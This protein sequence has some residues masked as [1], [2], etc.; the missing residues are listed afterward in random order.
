[1]KVDKELYQVH[2]NVATSWG[3]NTREDYDK[4]AAKFKG[5][6][7][8]SIA[9][10]VEDESSY[11]TIVNETFVLDKDQVMQLVLAG[12]NFKVKQEIKVA[13]DITKEIIELAEKPI[14][15]M[16]GDGT[17]GNTYNNRCEV[18]MPGNAMAFY[19]EVLLKE[20]ACTD[21]LQTALHSGWRLIA[22]CPQPNQ[23]RPDY[24]LGRFNPDLEIDGAA[25]R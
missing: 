4:E 18:H 16:T 12:I 1:M 17:I 20:D 14:K 22:A 13:L 23:R 6:E 8:L 2:V 19:N 25:E 9:P 3:K 15:I 5:I 24:I 10:F 21:E 7:F 11:Q